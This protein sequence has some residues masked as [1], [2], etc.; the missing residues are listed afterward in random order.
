MGS[1]QQSMCHRSQAVR[2][3]GPEILVGKQDLQVESASWASRR[4]RG[5]VPGWV[6]QPENQESRCGWQVQE[7]GRASVAAQVCIRQAARKEGFPRGR[8]AL[9]FYSDLPL[10]G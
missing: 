1:L 2:E 8:T 3:A 7:P 4:A 5:L 6:Q 9:L 10:I